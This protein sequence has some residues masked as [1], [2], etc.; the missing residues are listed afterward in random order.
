MKIDKTPIRIGV[1]VSVLL[2][3]G[4]S[5]IFSIS[6]FWN[7]RDID[8]EIDYLI[9]KASPEEIKKSNVDKGCDLKSFDVYP[10]QIS[11]FKRNNYIMDCMRAKGYSSRWSFP[12]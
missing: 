1:L 10:E 5:G 6:D 3:S 7:D 11:S 4:C 9:Y 2:L 12:H 8:R